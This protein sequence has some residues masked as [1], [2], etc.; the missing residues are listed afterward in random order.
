MHFSEFIHWRRRLGGGKGHV[1]PNVWGREYGIQNASFPTFHPSN[2]LAFGQ[3]M[4]MEQTIG[5]GY[6]YVRFRR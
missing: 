3:A 4:D 6:T 5:S 1:P 2:T